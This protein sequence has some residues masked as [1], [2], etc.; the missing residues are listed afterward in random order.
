M[1]SRRKRERKVWT[2]RNNGLIS[3]K[4]LPP[5]FAIENLNHYFIPGYNYTKEPIEPSLESSLDYGQEAL[6]ATIQDKEGL[7]NALRQLKETERHR[8][9][10]D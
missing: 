3:E 6:I 5:Y 2:K 9:R 8:G 10:I 4:M 7:I 1:E